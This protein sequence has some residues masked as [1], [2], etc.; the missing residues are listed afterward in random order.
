MDHGGKLRNKRSLSNI[1]LKY[2]LP[3]LIGTLLAAI[4]LACSWASYRA[5]K[6]SAL[7][8]GRERLQNLTQQLSTLL[9]QSAGN[10]L[11]K[12][13]SVANEPLMRA[14]VKSPET[15][16]PV[17]R[18]E[19]AATVQRTAGR[20]QHQSR[21][22]ECARSSFTCLARRRHD[23]TRRFDE[24]V[25]AGLIRAIQGGWWNPA[26]ERRSRFSSCGRDQR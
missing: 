16:S 19:A 12:T 25:Q 17:R 20:Q 14:F 13:A 8:V 23:A 21:S 1:S 5:V 24:R 2:R 26:V 9:Q 15:S 11:T 7:D 6:A 3:I 10:I 4:I 18:S 22:L